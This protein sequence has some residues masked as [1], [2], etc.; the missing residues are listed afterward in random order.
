MD[1]SIVL[2]HTVSIYLRLQAICLGFVE[3]YCSSHVPRNSKT[4][5]H[6]SPAS[7]GCCRPHELDASSNCAHDL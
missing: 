4:R 5:A 1:R 7:C 2:R 3:K 6:Q